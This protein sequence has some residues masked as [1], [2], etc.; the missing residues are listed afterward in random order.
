MLHPRKASSEPQRIPHLAN[1]ERHS[2]DEL[3]EMLARERRVRDE[4]TRQV[5]MNSREIKLLQD[6]HARLLCQ[7]RELKRRVSQLLDSAASLV[8]A[9]SSAS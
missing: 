8:G 1:L 3:L 6:Q 7:L 9:S 2:T 4:Y 5:E